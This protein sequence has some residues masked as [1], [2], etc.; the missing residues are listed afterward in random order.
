MVEKGSWETWWKTKYLAS[1]FN[2]V[3]KRGLN[4]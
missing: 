4:S 1:K 2:S 3:D